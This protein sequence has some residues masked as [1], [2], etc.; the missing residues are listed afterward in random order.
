MSDS[1]TTL[2]VGLVGTGAMAAVHAEAVREHIP[3]AT[4]VAVASEDPARAGAF[5]KAH[6]IAR[7]H[8]SHESIF[9]EAL[10]AVIIASSTNSH[11]Q[12][13]E[14]AAHRNLHVFCEKPLGVTAEETEPVLAAAA[15]NGAQFAV[16]FNRRFDD[17]FRKAHARVADGSIGTPQAIVIISR[18]PRAPTVVEMATPGRLFIGTMIHDFDMARFLMQDEVVA[19]SAHGSV[20]ANDAFKAHDQVD[21]AIVSL[22]FSR[23]GLGTIINSWHSNEGYDQRVELHGSNGL[24]RVDNPAE[25]A[26]DGDPDAPFFVQRYAASYVAELQA[27]FSAVRGATDDATLATGMDGK[28]ASLLAEAAVRSWKQGSV[29]KL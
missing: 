27:F 8:G 22:E 13:A 1:D 2:A 11:A 3:E 19:L 17:E 10:D 7:A 6:G 9:D 28:M 15:N 12:L 18:D 25:S 4:V 23:G 21:S 16:G 29:I 20:Q 14:Q 26:W 24:C 5:A